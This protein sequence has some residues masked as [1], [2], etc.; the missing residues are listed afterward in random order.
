MKKSLL[1]LLFF[2]FAACLSAQTADKN[3]LHFYV[4]TYTDNGSEGIYLF[5]LD[6]SSGKLH[7][8]GLAVLSEN[9]SFLTLTKDRKQLLSVR[10]IMDENNKSQGYIELFNVDE[11]PCYIEPVHSSL[12]GLGFAR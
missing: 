8:N 12:T 6:T 4:G 7:S 2:C 1:L 11:S 3:I 10:E 9:P 5:G